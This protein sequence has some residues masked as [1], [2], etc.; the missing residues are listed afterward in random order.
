MRMVFHQAHWWKAN[1]VCH[2]CNASLRPTPGCIPFWKYG[3]DFV[4]TTTQQFIAEQ[5]PAQPTP[6]VLLTSFDIKML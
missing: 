1:R 4:A 3:S 6:L 5:L 2:C